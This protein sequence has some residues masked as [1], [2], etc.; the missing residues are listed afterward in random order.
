M[1]NIKSFVQPRKD[2]WHTWEIDLD[3]IALG[4]LLILYYGKFE[5][6]KFHILCTSNIPRN[7]AETYRTK[8]INN[9]SMYRVSNNENYIVRRLKNKYYLSRKNR[10]VFYTRNVISPYWENVLL[11]NIFWI[12]YNRITLNST[13]Y[14]PPLS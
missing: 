12:P 8:I 1:K 14:H 10:N 13:L 11:I 2:W 3:I 4:K 7:T 6:I 9:S 5:V